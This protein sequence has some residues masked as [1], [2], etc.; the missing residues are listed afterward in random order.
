[1]AAS[2]SNLHTGGDRIVGRGQKDS[3]RLDSRRVPGASS[4]RRGGWGLDRAEVRVWGIET[5]S[6]GK[7]IVAVQA[8]G[9]T[10][11]ATSTRFNLGATG[12][13]TKTS[14]TVVRRDILVKVGSRYEFD[15][16]YYRGWALLNALPDLG[17]SL[18]PTYLPDEWD[19]Q[20]SER[21]ARG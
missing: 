20:S 4:F 2:G 21:I 15:S 16:P 12:A 7:E 9:L 14:Q 18:P 17:I 11:K 10:T 3:H 6:V 5:G 1:M 8:T 19:R 13:A